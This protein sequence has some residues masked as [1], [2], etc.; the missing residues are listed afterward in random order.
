MPLKFIHTADWHLG[1]QLHKE[2]LAADMDLFFDWLIDQIKTQDIDALLV[3]GDIFDLAN[4]ATDDR[5]RYYRL[6]ARLA[7]LCQ[8]VITGGNHDSNRMLDAPRELLKSLNIHIVGGI[9]KE[10]PDKE[11]VPLI[12][13]AGDVVA[14]ALAVPYLRDGDVRSYVA[15]LETQDRSEIMRAGIIEHYQRISTTAREQYPDLPIIGMGH[16]WLQ[17]SSASDSEREITIGTLDAVDHRTLSEHMD[18]FALGHIHRPQSVDKA[19]RIKYSGSAIP[20]SFSERSDQKRII[21]GNVDDGGVSTESLAVPSYR[22]LT[23]IKGSL[24]EVSAKLADYKSTTTLPSLVEI[25]VVEEDYDSSIPG[26]LASLTR[27]Y[28]EEPSFKIVKE[29]VTF[30]NN[31]KSIDK[32]YQE[33]THLDDLQPSEVFDQLLDNSASS[34]EV[35][36]TLRALFSE[37]LQD[38]SK[39]EG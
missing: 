7:G 3:A 38:V 36:E 27:S 26:S 21:I 4:P 14:V 12:D 2:S 24:E 13:A 29:R 15:T 1:K 9:D 17:G 30:N 25:H 11:I 22:E 37:V 8:V 20:L 23:S 39:G 34:P 28:T 5:R 18:Y 35:K 33:E 10:A 31:P 19:E 6:L 16:L 32:L